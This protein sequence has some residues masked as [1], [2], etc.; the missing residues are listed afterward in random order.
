MTRHFHWRLDATSILIALISP[1]AA[2]A[3]SA[4]KDESNSREL[5]EVIVTAQH[6]EENLQKAAI[7]VTTATGDALVQRGINDTRG[8]GAPRAGHLHRPE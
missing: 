6:L 8:S 4:T 2:L 5:E 1:A 3:Q 7:S